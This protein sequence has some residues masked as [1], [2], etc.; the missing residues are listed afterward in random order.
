MSEEDKPTVT[1]TTASTKRERSDSP[2]EQV[3]ERSV[4]RANTGVEIKSEEQDKHEATTT[5]MSKDEVVNE[6]QGEAEA[7][8]ADNAGKMQVETGIAN[9]AAPNG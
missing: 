2:S 4:K 7:P 5:D 9:T 8:A 3:D 6:V 1:P